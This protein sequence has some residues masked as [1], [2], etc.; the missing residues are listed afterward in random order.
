[1]K[2]TKLLGLALAVLSVAVISAPAAESVRVK[3]T[4]DLRVL[5]V[6]DS[7]PG[8]SRTALHDAFAASLAASMEI[9][10][11]GQVGVRMVEQKNLDKAAA[12]LREGAFDLALIFGTALPTN[13]QTDE[14]SVIPSV[15]KTGASTRAFNLVVGNADP[16]LANMLI[17][18]FNETL[19][20]PRF[21]EALY[22]LSTGRAVANN[23]L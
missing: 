5:L 16:V 3:S 11:R 6:D 2:S 9:R 21:Q 18:A 12:G 10:C 1:M 17:L 22:R 13:L 23:N 4:R 19:S 8:A 15:S 20:A 7:K 14:F